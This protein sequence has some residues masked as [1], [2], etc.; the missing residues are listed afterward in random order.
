[1]STDLAT[2]LTNLQA[3]GKLP[4]GQFALGKTKV[5]MKNKAAQQ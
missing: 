3:S 5:F 2:M 1:M 4:E